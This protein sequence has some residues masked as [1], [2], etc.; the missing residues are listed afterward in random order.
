MSLLVIHIK[1]I[2][3]LSNYGLLYKSLYINKDLVYNVL[4]SPHNS[5]NFVFDFEKLSNN[6]EKD[7]IKSMVINICINQE[8]I[9]TIAIE[10]LAF[11]HNLLEI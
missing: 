10:C 9:E 1:K 5:L 4:S 8:K 3:E 2:N 11:C 6:D 7:N